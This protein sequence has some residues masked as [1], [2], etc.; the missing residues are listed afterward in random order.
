MCHVNL[1]AI[2]A[3]AI[4]PFVSIKERE[5]S[6][7]APG[8]ERKVLNL[9]KAMD[10]QI[11]TVVPEPETPTEPDSNVPRSRPAHNQ[12]FVV[13]DAGREMGPSIKQVGDQLATIPH[14]R[15]WLNAWNDQYPVSYR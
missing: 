15:H 13:H 7:Q 1:A 9:S 3:S 6:F 11:C 14:P 2:S 8:S 4:V 12:I 5:A 10:T